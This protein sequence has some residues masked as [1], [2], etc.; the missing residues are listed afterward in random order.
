M[1]EY[2][3]SSTSC[4]RRHIVAQNDDDIVDMIVTPEPLGAER[5]G[6]AD[7]PVVT[8]V[9]R[10]VAPAIIRAQPAPG[11]RCGGCVCPVRTQESAQKWPAP[12]RGG[13]VAFA[14]VAEG[15]G[16]GSADRTA[17]CRA[18]RSQRSA[19]CVHTDHPVSLVGLWSRRCAATWPAHGIGRA[20]NNSGAPGRLC[21][22]ANEARAATS[23]SQH[24]QSC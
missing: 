2:R 11:K 14:L 15:G 5:V 19:R 10:I 6:M 22:S 13:S 20:H 24:S 8:R 7:R 21:R 12:Q 9:C 17:M 18:K 16:S 3:T 1:P 4:D 23:S